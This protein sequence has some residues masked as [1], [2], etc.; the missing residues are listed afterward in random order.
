MTEK[1]NNKY[2]GLCT[3]NS[4]CNSRPDMV[5]L[6]DTTAKRLYY[7]SSQYVIIRGILVCL[8]FRNCALTNSLIKNIEFGTHTNYQKLG[9]KYNILIIVSVIISERERL[10]Y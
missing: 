10:H 3:N 5:H 4:V 9:K 7:K 6:R 2:K 8:L 1:H